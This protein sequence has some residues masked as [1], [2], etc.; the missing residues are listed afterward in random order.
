MT[1]YFNKFPL[2]NY[3]GVPVRNIMARAAFDLQTKNNPANFGVVRVEDDVTGRADIIA[4]NYYGNPTY[5]WLVYFSNEIVDPY[6][7]MLLDSESFARFIVA[8]YG[9]IQR[10]QQ[11]VLVY[12]NNWADNENDKLTVAQFDAA[13]KIVKRYYTGVIDY[14]NRITE[15]VRIKA[16]WMKS[17]N[18]LRQLA[19]SPTD[20]LLVGDTIIQTLSANIIA[21]GEID[22][23]DTTNGKITVKHITG[24]FGV[25]GT[26]TIP[27]NAM[28]YT[29]TAVTNPFPSDNITTEEARFWSPYT[30]YQMEQELNE[31]KRNIK[32]LR[33]SLKNKA[34]EQLTDLMRS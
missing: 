25:S 5:D 16:D 12:I 7:D 10:A 23:V 33:S 11:K 28:T 14:S 20:Y 22:N 1:H 8:K 4:D 2:V 6:N 29:C 24:T 9:S 21:T 3:N 26:I 31:R 19:V 32:L 15:Y 13:S 18:K 27:N 17:T 30:A 34:D